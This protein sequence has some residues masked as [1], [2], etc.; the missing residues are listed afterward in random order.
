MIASQLNIEKTIIH[1][2]TPR[3]YVPPKE[4][5]LVLSNA[6]S[7]LDEDLRTYFKERIVD[8][9]RL[10]AFPVKAR[11]ERTSPTPELV[12]LHLTDPK[13][14]FVDLSQEVA[15]HLFAAQQKVRSSP[16]LLVVIAGSVNSGRAM[17]LLKLQKQQGLNLQRTGPEGAET[18]NLDHLR[19]LMLTDETRVYKIALFEADGVVRPDD[20]CGEVSDKQRYSSPE[21]RMA[22]FFLND[23][24]GCEVQDDPTQ[25][26]NTYYVS[27]EK[28]LNERVTTPEKQARYHRAFIADLASQSDKV[29]PKK[30][31]DEHLDKGDRDAF[32]NAIKAD[33]VP[34]TQFSKDTELIQGRLEEEEYVFSAGIRVRG[35]Q[36][37]LEEH[38]E[39]S[40]G[41]G[42][43]LEMLI[44]DRLKSVNGASKRRR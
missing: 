13:S 37:A 44:T 40:E 23:F 35:S 21:K 24:L 14:N 39:I 3:M 12:H 33:G 26:T 2:I 5:E 10:A 41:D 29:A 17:V 8:S 43:V 11:E 31:A 19:R 27:G 30:F 9:L 7:P 16:G 1:E 32:L 22:A 42:K 28:F 18:Y 38:S 6:L 34:T 36:E 25:V 15:K 4:P 20:L